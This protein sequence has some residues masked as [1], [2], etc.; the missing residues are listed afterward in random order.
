MGVADGVALSAESL[1]VGVGLDV[2]VLSDDAPPDGAALSSAVVDGVPDEV[3]AGVSSPEFEDVDDESRP[4]TAPLT[5]VPLPPLKLPPD[6][7]SYVVIPAMV[8]PKTRA[9]AS[10]GRFQL[11]TRAR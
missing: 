10:S 4:V 3:E 2:V 6:T 9:A 1:G 5:V 7:S 8:T 11:L